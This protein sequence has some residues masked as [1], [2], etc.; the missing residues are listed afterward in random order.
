VKT[1]N[2]VMMAQRNILKTFQMKENNYVLMLG[3]RKIMKILQM[4]VK[5]PQ[6]HLIPMMMMMNFSL[7]VNKK[8]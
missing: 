2:Q 4:K 7:Q 3:K 5:N 8:I 6:K 1:K